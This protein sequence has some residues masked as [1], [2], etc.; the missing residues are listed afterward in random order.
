M[1]AE[2]EAKGAGFA[3]AVSEHT[4]YT[5][6]AV[7]APPP[8]SDPSTST[9]RS[10]RRA[11]VLL[12]RA[13]HD[14]WRDPCRS[15]GDLEEATKVYEVLGDLQGLATACAANA[16][17]TRAEV[18]CRQISGVQD[19]MLGMLADARADYL[20]AVELFEAVGKLP[21]VSESGL[22]PP[23]AAQRWDTRMSGSGRCIRSGHKD[24]DA[25]GL[26]P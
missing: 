20:H 25:I 10:L 26:S 3:R 13:I 22:T 4:E 2:S 19:P 9:R 14:S 1:A 18:H 21:R 11:D 12:R 7:P 8:P 15:R 5:Y 17:A 6:R 16:E 24:A 23:W